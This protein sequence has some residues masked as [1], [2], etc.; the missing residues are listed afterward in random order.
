MTN[1]SDLKVTVHADC[2]N[3]PKAQVRDWVLY[4]VTFS[5]HGKG[6]IISE[7]LTYRV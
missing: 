4:I 6:A 3:A 2:G 7:V 5:G 1:S